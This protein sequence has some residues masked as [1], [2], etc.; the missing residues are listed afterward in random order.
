MRRS[1]CTLV[2][3]SRRRSSGR[4]GGRLVSRSRRR[5]IDAGI[6]EEAGAGAPARIQAGAVT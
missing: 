2:S 4:A 3:K 6:G 5:S 1:G